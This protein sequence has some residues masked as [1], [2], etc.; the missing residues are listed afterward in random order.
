MVGKALQGIRK[1][2]TIVSDF[3]VA[4]S[5]TPKRHSSPD[6]A[7]AA[8]KRVRGAMSV[9]HRGAGGTSATDDLFGKELRDG[10]KR[11]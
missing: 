11:P 7:K 6:P 8:A 3:L 1:G 9:G 10:H 2:L 5:R 4:L